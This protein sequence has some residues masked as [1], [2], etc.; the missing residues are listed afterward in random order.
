MPS[1]ADDYGTHGGPAERVYEIHDHTPNEYS[2]GLDAERRFLGFGWSSTHTPPE[3]MP[4]STSVAVFSCWFVCGCSFI[5]LL[6]IRRRL[7][8]SKPVGGLCI[9]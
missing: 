4:A 2:D 1:G 9:S 6:W 8:S 7:R 5:P 3:M